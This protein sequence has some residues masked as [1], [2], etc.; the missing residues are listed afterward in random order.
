MTTALGSTGKSVT[1]SLFPDILDSVTAFPLATESTEMSLTSGKDI[2][3][4]Y[5][6]EETT[7]TRGLLICFSSDGRAS[8]S[9]G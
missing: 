4:K 7:A 6:E 9:E 1:P 2:L 8:T 3:L 5:F